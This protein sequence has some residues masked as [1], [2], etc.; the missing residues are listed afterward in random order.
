MDREQQLKA[1]YQGNLS[2]EE[3]EDFLQWYHSKEGEAYMS[4]KLKEQWDQQDPV[5]EEYSSWDREVLFKKIS[6]KKEGSNQSSSDQ[7]IKLKTGKHWGFSIAASLAILFT[8]S[9][10]GYQYMLD[11]QTSPIETQAMITK[12]NP[13][14]QKSKI[15]LPDGSKVYLNAESTIRY[16]K[17]FKTNRQVELEGE[18]FFEV[19]SDKEHPFSVRSKG[20]VTKALG[21]AFNIQAYKDSPLTEVALTHGKVSVEEIGGAKSGEL[22]PGEAIISEGTDSDFRK[23]KIDVE[24]VLYWKEGILHF[25]EDTFEEVVRTLERWY[26]VKITVEG[27]YDKGFLCSGTFDKNEY[28]DNVLNILSHSSGFEYQINKRQINM[29]FNP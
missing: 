28:L 13:A 25:D 12:S 15:I 26:N 18:A 19:F 20:L 4:S 8:V 9:I 14:G 3:A 27:R 2:K 5:M 17:E 23:E 10:L 24:K 29:K 11:H 7:S 22:I 1:F 6:T 21:T 16:R